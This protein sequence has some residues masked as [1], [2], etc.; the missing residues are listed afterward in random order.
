MTELKMGRTRWKKSPCQYTRAD[1]ESN[2]ND[3]NT[4]LLYRIICTL[5]LIG[6]VDKHGV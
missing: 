5:Y 2:R 1:I 3:N 6:L 4:V